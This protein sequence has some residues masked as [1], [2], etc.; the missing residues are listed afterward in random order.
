MKTLAPAWSVSFGG[1]K[2]RGQESQAVIND[3]II[4]ITESYSRRLAVDAKSGEKLW[5]YD[6]KLPEGILPC[7]DVV[8]RG[9]V[10]WKDKVYFTTLD[11]RH[12]GGVDLLQL[13]D[14]ARHAGVTG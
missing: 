2:Q 12:Q 1:E 5:Q 9:A 11:A 4:Y 3:G 7:C 6:A 13:G 8:N 14:F 10:L